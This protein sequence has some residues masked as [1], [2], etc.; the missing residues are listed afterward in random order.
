MRGFCSERRRGRKE[1]ND[2]RRKPKWRRRQSAAGVFCGGVCAHGG[3]LV[4]QARRLK[5]CKRVTMSKLNPH[6]HTSAAQGQAQRQGSRGV[7]AVGGSRKQIMINWLTFY[8]TPALMHL[9]R[10]CPLA[11]RRSYFNSSGEPFVIYENQAVALIAQLQ[12][13]SRVVAAGGGEGGAQRHRSLSDSSLVNP[14][15]IP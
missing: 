15:F 13:G 11:R 8:K 6:T 5:L 4:C 7:L 9:G 3:T 10:P 12:S 1:R 14:P 2:A